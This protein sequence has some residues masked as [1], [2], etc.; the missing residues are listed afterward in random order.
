MSDPM[1]QDL[2]PLHEITEATIA[3]PFPDSFVYSNIS[4]FS[5]S[6]MDVRISFAEAMP[7]KSAKA[8]VGIVMPPEHAAHVVL[9]L[10]RQLEFFEERFGP[11]RLPVWRAFRESTS[12]GITREPEPE[13]G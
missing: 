5:T 10:L 8:R 1:P 9:S 6:F 12:G 7:D 13:Q 3:V 11:I 2:P 4:A